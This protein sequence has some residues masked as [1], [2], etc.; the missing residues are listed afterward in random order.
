MLFEHFIKAIEDATAEIAKW[1]QWKR[2][3]STKWKDGKSKV[4]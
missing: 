1:P 4:Q 2:D 3:A